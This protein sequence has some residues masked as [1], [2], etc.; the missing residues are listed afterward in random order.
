MS[1]SRQHA[2][3]LTLR[4]SFVFV[5]VTFVSDY[6]PEIPLREISLDELGRLIATLSERNLRA[7]ES[8]L[9]ALRLPVREH[10]LAILVHQIDELMDVVT[11]HSTE[12]V[13]AETIEELVGRLLADRG[14]LKHR[15]AYQLALWLCGVSLSR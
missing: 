8:A 9:H 4:G 15:I 6:K 3:G 13:L 7:R 1:L 2:H 5:L 14:N 11:Q 10:Q 12:H